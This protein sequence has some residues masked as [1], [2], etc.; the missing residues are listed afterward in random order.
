MVVVIARRSFLWGD[1]VRARGARFR[2]SERDAATLERAGLATR[3]QRQPPHRIGPSE[4][5]PAPVEHTG[6]GWYVVRGERVRGREAAEAL[7]AGVSD[8][9]EP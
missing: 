1:R 4:T 8:A 2:V 7:A 6:G 3:L 9:G 5:K